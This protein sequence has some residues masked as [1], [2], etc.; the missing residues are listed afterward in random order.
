MDITELPAGTEHLLELLDNLCP[1]RCIAPGETLEQAHRYAGARE[2]IES[3]IELW[4]EQHEGSP[5][6]PGRD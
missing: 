6:D 4:K 5:E 1:P 2:L 3:L